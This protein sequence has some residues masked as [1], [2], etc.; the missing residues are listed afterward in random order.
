VSRT[1]CLVDVIHVCETK[2]T[3]SGPFFK[4]DEHEI[5]QWLQCT[6]LK[7]VGVGT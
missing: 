3:L 4:Y 1:A 2:K 7:Y 6:E 5:K